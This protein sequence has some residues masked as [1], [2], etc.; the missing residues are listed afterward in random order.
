MGDRSVDPV[1]VTRRVRAPEPELQRYWKVLTAYERFE[2]I[3][4]VILGWTI[5]VI[6][7]VALWRLLQEVFH[8]LVLGSMDPLEHGTFQQVFGA[9]MTLLIALEFKHSIVKVVHRRSHIIQ[10]R[11]VIL[12]AQLALARKFILI[13]FE[14]ITALEGFALGFGVLVLAIAH[15]LLRHSERE[16][17]RE[18]ELLDAE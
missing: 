16:D 9:I 13:D 3:V 18:E 2:Q 17:R 6:V 4:A 8:S 10:V 11:T 5:A 12:I 7:V 15:W 1:D 14:K